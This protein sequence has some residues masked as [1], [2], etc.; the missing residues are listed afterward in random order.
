MLIFSGFRY[1][2]SSGGSTSLLGQAWVGTMCETP[3]NGF[4]HY[5]NSFCEDSGYFGSGPTGAHELAHK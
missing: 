2:T 4:S 1:D 3:G 5:S